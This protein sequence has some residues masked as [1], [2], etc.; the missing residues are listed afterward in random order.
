MDWSDQ[1][2]HLRLRDGAFD[3]DYI[4]TSAGNRLAAVEDLGMQL[5]GIMQRIKGGELPVVAVAAFPQSTNTITDPTL[6]NYGHLLSSIRMTQS[7]GEMGRTEI[8]RV[9]TITVD[10]IV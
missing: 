1:T 7:A 9:E 8:I 3:T 2:N 5:R 6:F 10:G 4:A